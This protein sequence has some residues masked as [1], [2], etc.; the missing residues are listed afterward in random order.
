MICSTI[1]PMFHSISYILEDAS[2]PTAPTKQTITMEA[3]IESNDN[4]GAQIDHH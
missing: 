2:D 4:Q 3:N 1:R